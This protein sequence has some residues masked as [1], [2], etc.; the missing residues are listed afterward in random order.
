MGLADVAF[1]YYE[2]AA[3]ISKNVDKI[4]Y[5]ASLSNIGLYKIEIN[6]FDEAITILKEVNE[7]YKTKNYILEQ[8]T[9]LNGLVNA[10]IRKGNLDE[11]E[12]YALE[13]AEI[14]KDL[15]YKSNAV[16]TF[17]NLAK[18]NLKKNNIQAATKYAL[19]AKS[20]ADSTQV[21][22]DLNFSSRELYQV[23]KKL[24]KLDS[25]LFYHEIYKNYS[26][27]I[28]NVQ[29]S[30][31]LGRIEVEYEYKSKEEKLRLENQNALLEKEVE[32]TNQKYAILIISM[33]GFAAIIAIAFLL[34]LK[35]EKEKNNLIL[36][37]KQQKIEESNKKLEEL[38]QQKNRLFSIIAH[39][40]RGPLSS[41]SM[42]L[43]MANNKMLTESELFEML[44]EANKKLESLRELNNNLL[45]W[46]S[47]SLTQSLLNK[48][49]VNL[50]QTVDRIKLLYESNLKFKG[51]T[52]NNNVPESTILLIDI[53]TLN[54]LLRNLISNAIK[55]CNANSSI[56]ISIIEKEFEKIICIEDT[57]VGMTDEISSN[58]FNNKP[59]KTLIGT[60]NEKGSGIGLMLCKTFIEENGGAIWVDY[61]EVGK[62]TKICF[63]VPV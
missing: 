3:E 16:G 62:G 44:D 15:V 30:K 10:L 5:Y 6:Q 33:L 47:K 21:L 25:A 4:T 17:T 2:K 59:S 34:K 32:L 55:F 46:A 36:L 40:L 50:A 22:S 57:G 42:F 49:Q 52:F 13:S 23:Y 14:N 11:A 58:L 28:F 39:D 8:T 19:K 26:D 56:S 48:E 37:N 43:N 24:N 12:A 61:S 63:K 38:I 1:N 41:L 53:N 7:F 31:Q 51:I 18:I 35:R 60:A 45:D 27:S 9:S 54:L 20:I 29:K